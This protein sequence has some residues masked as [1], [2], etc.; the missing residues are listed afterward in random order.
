MNRMERINA[1]DLSGNDS[2]I[3]VSRLS[4][5]IHIFSPEEASD[6]VLTV[7]QAKE[8]ISAIKK[9]INNQ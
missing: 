5:A 7:K 4:N 3:H 6:V 2:Y 8:L 9:C 1:K